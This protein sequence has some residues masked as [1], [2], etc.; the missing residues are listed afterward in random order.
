VVVVVV[1][2][3]RGGGGGQ[4]VQLA[5]RPGPDWYVHNRRPPPHSSSQAAFLQQPSF[6][7]ILRILNT[8]VDGRRKVQYAL[9]A[10]PGVGRRISNLVCKRAG[11]DLNKR[12]GEVTPA[13]LEK[14]VSILAEPESKR[15]PVWMLNRRK[16][17]VDGKN[18]QLVSNQIATKMREDLEA[19]KKMRIHRG[20]RHYWCLKV[21]GQHTGTTGRGR[22][23]ALAAAS[24]EK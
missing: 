22:S 15:I 14:V 5:A 9:T 11:I 13:E 24:K 10:I 8:N 17:K 3:E 6:Q 23:H 20:L 12:A 4:W 19:L 2:V 21:R 7:F 16:D 18:S 1:V